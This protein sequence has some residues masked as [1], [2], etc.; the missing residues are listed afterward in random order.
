MMLKIF[1]RDQSR[2]S[3]KWVNKRKHF[4]LGNRWDTMSSC[5]FIEKETFD[6]RNHAKFPKYEN[7]YKKDHNKKRNHKM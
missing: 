6:C 5:S 4:Q 1:K 3:V 2:Y 7:L